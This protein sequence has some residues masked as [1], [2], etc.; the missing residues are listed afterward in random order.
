LFLEVYIEPTKFIK[1]PMISDDSVSNLA[2]FVPKNPLHKC[3]HQN[4]NVENAEAAERSRG[5][6]LPSLIGT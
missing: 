1:N 4:Q 2:T 5:S 3:P 6:A